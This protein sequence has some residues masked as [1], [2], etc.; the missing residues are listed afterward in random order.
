MI[1]ISLYMCLNG[2]D[3]KTRGKTAEHVRKERLLINYC[4]LIDTRAI[5]SA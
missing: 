4:I 1:I 2:I 3:C 5:V